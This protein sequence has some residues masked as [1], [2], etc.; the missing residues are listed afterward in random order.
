MKSF[1]KKNITPILFICFSI[2]FV[3][4]V[5]SPNAKLKRMAKE[6]NE[7]CPISIDK[8]TSLDSCKITVDNVY[9]C[10]HTISGIDDS[11]FS[12]N[13]EFENQM[14]PIVI[15]TIKINPGIQFFKDNNVIF[16]YI[17]NNSSGEQIGVIKILPEDY[18]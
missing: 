18:K 16:E 3:Q 11:A 6:T 5:E 2:F 14:K 10:Y 1:Y 15:S 4:C 8:Y 7:K 12:S 17:Y 13:I 9:Q